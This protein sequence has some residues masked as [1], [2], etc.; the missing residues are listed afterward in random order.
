MEPSISLPTPLSHFCRLPPHPLW[1]SPSYRTSSSSSVCRM[2]TRVMTRQHCTTLST[3]H[4][5][6]F[7]RRDLDK[8]VWEG[9]PGRTRVGHRPRDRKRPNKDLTLASQVPPMVDPSSKEGRHSHRRSNTRAV[10]P[11]SL[12]RCKISSSTLRL[13]LSACQ[14]CRHLR[15]H[16][17]F[18]ISA[19]G[20]LQRN[21]TMEVELTPRKTESRHMSRACLTVQT[22]PL[23][24]RSPPTM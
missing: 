2:A 13:Y 7:R 1:I 6:S 15:S 3:R 18:R 10:M 16:Q 5:Q 9:H 24:L 22:N 21:L 4:N 8:R 23:T 20:P 14:R 11:A 12:R 19:L 17:P